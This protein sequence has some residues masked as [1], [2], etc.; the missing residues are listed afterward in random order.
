VDDDQV[1]LVRRRETIADLLSGES[2]LPST[3]G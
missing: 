3:A 1:H 2:L